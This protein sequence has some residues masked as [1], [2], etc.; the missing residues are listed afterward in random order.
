MQ[1]APSSIAPKI[2]FILAGGAGRRLGG[3]DKGLLDLGGRRLIDVIAERIAPQVDQIIIAG[4]QTYGDAY[5]AIADQ[6]PDGGPVA[7]LESAYRAMT[8]NAD[9]ANG[10]LSLPVDC[11][12]F[13]QDLYDRLADEDA[14]AIATTDDGNHPTFGYWRMSD[15]RRAH[16]DN[17]L[18]PGVSLRSLVKAAKAR[19]VFFPDKQAFLNINTTETLAQAQQMAL[20]EP[21]GG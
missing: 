16:A 13:P 14:S 6:T 3:A 18:A 1:T 8:E 4:N 15:L 20:D 17:T 19:E 9:G 21:T 2:A 10:F 7:G 5:E 12:F 11:P